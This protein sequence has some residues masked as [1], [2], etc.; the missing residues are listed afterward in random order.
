MFFHRQEVVFLVETHV[1]PVIQDFLGLIVYLAAI[2]IL[3]LVQEEEAK[4]LVLHPL[5]FSPQHK[6]EL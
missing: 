5:T 6:A 2:G 3:L 4:V 1:F